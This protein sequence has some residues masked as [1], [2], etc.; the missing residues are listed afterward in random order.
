MCHINF[1]V[2]A[3]VFL[4]KATLLFCS[5]LDCCSCVCVCVCV[6]GCNIATTLY[7]GKKQL[8]IFPYPVVHCL[9]LA[10]VGA[11]LSENLAQKV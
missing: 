1:K 3:A 4:A 7:S 8:V 10:Y 5:F 11:P 2:T 6:C 9:T